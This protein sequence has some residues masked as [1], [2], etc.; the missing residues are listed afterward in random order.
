MSSV[1]MKTTLH[2]PADAAWQIIRDF[3]NPG[4]FIAAVTACTVEGSGPGAVRTLTL[5]GG[6]EVV[7][8]LESLDDAART[9]TYVILSSPL[10][11][12]DYVATM[13]VRELGPDECEVAW[14]STFEPAGAPEAEGKAIVEGVYA[15]GFEG[16]KRLLEG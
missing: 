9:L 16:L 8:R 14:S 12:R 7:E 3:G 5:E 11:L 2:A 15:T 10:P 6:A 1:S 13:A 4:R